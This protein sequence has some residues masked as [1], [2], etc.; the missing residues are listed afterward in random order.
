MTDVALGLVLLSAVV[1][2]T[3]NFL[4]KDA[5]NKEVF[6]WWML[7]CSA[8]LFLPVAVAVGW[9]DPIVHP[10]WWF[11]LGTT[12][13]HAVYFLFLGR[14]YAHADLSLV[15]PIARGAGPALV[16][17]LGV[18][19]LQEEVT[20]LAIAGIVAVVLGIYTV[21]WWGRLRQVFSDPF[22]LFREQGTRYA[23][24]TGLFIAVYSVWDKEGVRYVNPL[25]FMYLLSGGTALWLTPN[26]M[27]SHGLDEIRREWRDNGRAI[28]GAGL[29]TFTGYGLI[30]FALRL[31]PVS[32]VAP[33]RE[34]GI[35]ISVLL[36]SLVLK[37]PFGRGRILGSGLIVLGVALI[38]LAP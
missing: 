24:L 22:K 2:A 30:L 23:A 28:V 21:Y 7:A 14:S 20:G 9:R 25:L 13:L 15:Y 4:L 19:V 36:G 6:I 10:G 12:I 34:I 26:I 16:P 17:I 11:V 5:R 37:E 35:V 33:S 18:V 38:A 8:V 27:R 32:Y 1:H 3:W 31:S 29:L